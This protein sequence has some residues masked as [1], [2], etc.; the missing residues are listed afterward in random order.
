MNYG[1]VTVIIGEK[2]LLPALEGEIK[3]MEPGKR[4][5]FELEPDKAF[6]A[7]DQKLVKVFNETEFRKSDMDPIPGLNVNINGIRGKVLSVSG[8]RVS[9][10]FNHPLSGKILVYDLTVECIVDNNEDKVKSII[11]YHTGIKSKDLNVKI[12]EK[13]V[14]VGLPAK[15]DAN[16][17]AR[18][19]AASEIIKWV[20]V[21]SVKLEE[22]FQKKKQ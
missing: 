2:M 18:D 6:G 16:P 10:D 15:N 14:V 8:G 11:Q 3:S 17:E 13:E 20:N 4:K 12:N 22:T 19:K 1:P 7:R 9:V 21:D 5:T